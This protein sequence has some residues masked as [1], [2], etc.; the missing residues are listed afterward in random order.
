M[1][2]VQFVKE[3]VPKEK[4]EKAREALDELLMDAQ[5]AQFIET[6]NEIVSCLRGTLNE[7]KEW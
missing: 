7:I 6:R 4:R 2:I 5:D 3:Y 1:T